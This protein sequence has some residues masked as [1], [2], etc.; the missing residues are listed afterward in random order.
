MLVLNN[1]LTKKGNKIFFSQRTRCTQSE[2]NFLN[3]TVMFDSDY[4]RACFAESE[5]FK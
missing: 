1:S 4:E 5:S 2:N 3:D